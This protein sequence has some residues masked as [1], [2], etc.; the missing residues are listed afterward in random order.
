MITSKRFCGAALVLLCLGAWAAQADD[1]ETARATLEG[2]SGGT[3]AIQTNEFSRFVA[4][5]QRPADLKTGTYAV[6]VSDTNHAALVQAENWRA[7]CAA[8]FYILGTNESCVVLTYVPRAHRLSQAILRA[9]S[10]VE[11]VEG[12][13]CAPGKDSSMREH[14]NHGRGAETCRT[15][16]SLQDGLS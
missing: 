15:I 2:Q 1:L 8:P 3:W 13:E 4:L 7:M 5:V 12:S 10:L 11:F 16:A 6:F 9:L 14:G